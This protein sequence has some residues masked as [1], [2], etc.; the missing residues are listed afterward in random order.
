MSNL[1]KYG[2]ICTKVRAMYGRML[3][4]ED[5][6]RV[7]ECRDLREFASLLRGFPG[8]AKAAAALPAGEPDVAQI[9]LALRQQV[10]A[11]YEGIF[12]FASQSDK[13]FL[14]FQ[15]YREEYLVILAAI[16]RLFSS[17]TLPVKEV[18][19][20]FFRENTK[21]DLDA[22][23]DSHSLADIAA[24]AQSSLY[25]GALEALRGRYG[26]EL[27]DYADASALLESR[28]HGAI[29]AYLRK[30][31]GDDSNL[32]R[33]LGTEADL[34]NLS[35]I[36]RLRTRFPSSME[37]ID[38]LLVPIRYRLKDS[39]IERLREAPSDDAFAAILRDSRWGGI[40]TELDPRS[41]QISYE[42][43]L[44]NF[45]RR[46]IHSAE[47]GICVPQAYLTLKSLEHD[48]LVRAAGCVS[49]GVP[50]LDI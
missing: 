11:E 3:K 46:Q 14:L 30:K 33:N 29:W 37:R 31:R 16:R 8:W 47:P 48:R 44:F 21:L 7:N 26:A 43:A 12:R 41:A 42:K 49:Y 9:T 32:I 23:L 19:S 28:Y 38:E 36:I 50:P 15:V 34:L 45:C 40:F 10:N 2:A 35:S 24:A 39:L 20:D 18:Y 27:P 4:E 22:M 17:R 6:Q 13:K 1:A 5:W 25:S